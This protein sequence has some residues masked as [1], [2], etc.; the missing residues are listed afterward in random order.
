MLRILG[1]S[2]I[3]LLLFEPK[4]TYKTQEKIEPINLIFIDN[5][6]SISQFATSDETSKIVSTTKKT[7]NDINGESEVFI[8]G[9][10]LKKI[11]YKQL[12]SIKFID[13]GT[14]LSSI[15]SLAKER[16][17]LSSVVIFSDGIITE[18]KNPVSE[19]QDLGIPIYIVGVGDTSNN[20]DVK[21]T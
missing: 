8:F 7:I 20:N 2:L 17:N 6:K 19:A 12:D 1:L 10:T 4:L 9:K 16:E 3:L 14:N 21:I 11:D 18:G 5:S 13:Q 15:I